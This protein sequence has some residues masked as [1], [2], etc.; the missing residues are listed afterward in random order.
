MA[1]SKEIQKKI[2][3]IGTSALTVRVQ[4][5]KLEG[6]ELEYAKSLLRKRQVDIDT[7]L[8]TTTTTTQE[9]EPLKSNDLPELFTIPEYN[10]P[11]TQEEYDVMQAAIEEPVVEYTDVQTQKQ[12]DAVQVIVE[13]PVAITLEIAAKP[14]KEKKV[15]STKKSSKHEKKL[16]IDENGKELTKSDYMRRLIRLN[17]N[18][19]PKEMDEHLIAAGFSTAYYSELDRCR[20][21][22]GVY[23]SKE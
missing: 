14:A 21:N 11:Q 15:K 17:N 10:D 5:G 22:V 13:E 9:E 2:S 4:L 3:K 18:I 1:L 16:Y 20:K 23:P 6:E 19:K 7:I 12:Y 8:S